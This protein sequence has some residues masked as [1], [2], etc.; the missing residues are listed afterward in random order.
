MR[1]HLPAEIHIGGRVARSRVPEFLDTLA[2]QSVAL[3]WGDARFC[4]KTAEDLLEN[5]DFRRD[6]GVL[7]LCHPAA[8]GGEFVALE[9]FLREAEI[10]F[11]RYTSGRDEVDPLWACYRPELGLFEFAINAR[12]ERQIDAAL[13]VQFIEQL[14]AA[15]GRFAAQKTMQGISLL[16]AVHLEARK[17]LATSCVPL[18]PFQIVDRAAG[19]PAQPL[20]QF[21]LSGKTDDTSRL[22]AGR[23]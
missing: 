7:R 18:P 22:S 1:Y 11:D 5:R 2:A 19:Q 12:H 23:S 13:L 17:V 20:S 9:T 4:P 3:E 14:E 21:S 16:R 10:P 8:P 6:F 15:L